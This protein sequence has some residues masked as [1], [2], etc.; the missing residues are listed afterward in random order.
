[1]PFDDRL[2]GKESAR[3]A[4]CHVLG[5]I[6]YDVLTVN[7]YLLETRAAVAVIHIQIAVSSATSLTCV[8]SYQARC[9]ISEQASSILRLGDIFTVSAESVSNLNSFS[10]VKLIGDGVHQLRFPPFART[11]RI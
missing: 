2:F 11:I 7:N 8:H 3:A 6:V 10:L 4:P 5:P 9:S 1:M